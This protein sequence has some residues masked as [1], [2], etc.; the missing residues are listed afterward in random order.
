MMKKEKR[1]KLTVPAKLQALKK[2]SLET[3]HTHHP[4][5]TSRET[6]HVTPKKYTIFNMSI[7]LYILVRKKSTK[8]NRTNTKQSLQ[9]HRI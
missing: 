2:R 6:D 5:F 3:L 4:T 7:A 1:K 8:G 9:R